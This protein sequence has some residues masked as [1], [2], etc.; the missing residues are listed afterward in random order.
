MRILPSQSIHDISDCYIA[1]VGHFHEDHD[2]RRGAEAQRLRSSRPRR[3]RKKKLATE[4]PQ[5]PSKAKQ[6]ALPM[7]HLTFGN[8]RKEERQVNS[9]THKRRPHRLRGIG[10]RRTH[11]PNTKQRQVKKTQTK[12]PRPIRTRT[13][14][15]PNTSPNHLYTKLLL[16]TP[17][18]TEKRPHCV[19]KR[20]ERREN[21]LIP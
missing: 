7:L 5:Q 12:L 1:P 11:P 19:H 9:K 15:V 8:P 21:D 20:R 4:R 14:A 16:H 18:L 13:I 3:V 2:D 10:H 6:H 17:R